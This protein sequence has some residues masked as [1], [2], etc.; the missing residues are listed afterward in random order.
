MKRY[1]VYKLIPA[2][3][4]EGIEDSFS[5]EV[6]QFVN[7]FDTEE[8]AIAHVQHLKKINDWDNTKDFTI[9]PIY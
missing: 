3:K 5:L 2:T 9:L 7:W 1:H 6:L 8:E 4:L